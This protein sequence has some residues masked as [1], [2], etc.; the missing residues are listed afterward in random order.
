M[1][2]IFFIILFLY[3][4]SIFGQ[5]NT[6]HEIDIF[7]EECVNENQTMSGSAYCYSEAQIKWD[8]ELNRVYKELK[9]KLNSEQ[10][11]ILK[12]AQLKWIAFRDVEFELLETVYSSLLGT[13]YLADLAFYKM[14]IVKKRVL[15][16][17]N[18]LYTLENY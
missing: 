11:E 7:L 2:K 9:V 1:G 16:L 13:I 18:Y 15:E 10:K 4:N 3:V 6:K 14:E 5:E 12:N 17:E 8:Y